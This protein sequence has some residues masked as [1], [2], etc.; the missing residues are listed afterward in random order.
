MFFFLN[1]NNNNNNNN[2]KNNNNNSWAA[3][4]DRLAMILDNK[5]LPPQERPIAIVV[6]PNREKTLSSENDSAD[7]DSIISLKNN[8]LYYYGLNLSKSLH[9]QNISTLFYH[10]PPQLSLKTILGNIAKTNASHVI[11]VG[12]NEI[13]KGKVIIKDLDNK[14]QEECKIEDIQQYIIKIKSSLN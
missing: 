6:I 11:L 2:N 1:N 7:I 4:I 9:V 3:G 12:E 14:I 8:K 5:I 10:H 13:T